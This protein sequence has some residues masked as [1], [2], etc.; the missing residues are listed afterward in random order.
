MP[1]RIAEIF[2]VDAPV[3]DT[4]SEEG[5]D[6]ATAR[7]ER[8]L[9]RLD[10]S[11]RSLNGRV[12]AHARI[13]ADTQKL[14]ADRARLAAELDREAARARRLDDSNAEVSRRLVAAMETIRAVIAK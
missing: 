14:M 10:A 12:R 8:A 3:T 5:Y 11:V 4:A 1:A 6:A 9:T 7:L 13:E 2:T